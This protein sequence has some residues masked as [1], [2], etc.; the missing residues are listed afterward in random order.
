V[1]LAETIIYLVAAVLLFPAFGGGVWLLESA[2]RQVTWLGSTVEGGNRAKVLAGALWLALFLG[3]ILL[4]GLA[5]SFLFFTVGIFIWEGIGLYGAFRW[6]RLQE[7]LTI[8]ELDV[9]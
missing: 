6:Y 4:S 5:G 7:I 3:I 8:R 2:L 9:K 1:P